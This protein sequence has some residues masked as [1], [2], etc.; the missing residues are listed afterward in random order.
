MGGIVEE[1]TERERERSNRSNYRRKK[2]NFQIATENL[3]FNNL[4]FSNLSEPLFLLAFDALDI[5]AS[6]YI[7]R[8]N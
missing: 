2:V 8:N 4:I 3:K 1:N 5:D 7:E 6:T